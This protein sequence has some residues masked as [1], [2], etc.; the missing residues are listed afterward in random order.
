[1]AT[2]EWLSDG[3]VASWQISAAYLARNGNISENLPR[4][5]TL[6]AHTGG[7]PDGDVSHST[8]E[9]DLELSFNLAGRSL[10]KPR[11]N[12]PC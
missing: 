3:H 6:E 8:T 11:R 9:A 10:S 12:G 7:S 2:D 4:K 1:M 5:G